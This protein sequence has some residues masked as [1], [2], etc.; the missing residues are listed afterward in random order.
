[1]IGIIMVF[2]ISIDG[3]FLISFINYYECE[4]IQCLSDSYFVYYYC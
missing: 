1:M 2:A 3:S 4:F